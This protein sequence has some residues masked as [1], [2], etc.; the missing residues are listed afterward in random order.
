MGEW[1]LAAAIGLVS[2]V[3]S[4]AFGI[5]GGIITTPAIR[6]LLGAP[7]LVA[8]GTPLPVIIPTAITGAVSYH[9]RGLVDVRSGLVLGG[10][11]A[12]TAIAGALLADRVGGTVV[13][14]GTAALILYAAADMAVQAL[15]PPVATPEDGRAPES[16]HDTPRRPAA[17]IVIGVVAG[18]YSGF[19]GLGGGVLLVPMLSRW[20][21][22]PIKRAIG[23]S[24][25]AVMLLAIPSTIAHAL[26]GNVDWAIALG[27]VIGVVPGALIG[28]HLTQRARDRSI[29]IAFAILLLSVGVWLA[30]T[31]IGALPR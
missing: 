19:F 22:F 11:G 7:A 2:G 20:L 10:A 13:L 28:A 27:L 6:L 16:E 18:L 24:L 3:L 23:T 12:A 15:R 29:R 31:E 26:L 30:A 21:S 8:V 14:L 1:L 5:G 9:R 17:L 25:V 4:G